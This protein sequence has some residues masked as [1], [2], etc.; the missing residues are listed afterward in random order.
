MVGAIVAGFAWAY[1]AKIFLRREHR[2]VIAA[3]LLSEGRCATCAYPLSDV[4]PAGTLV[5]C[6]ECGSQWKHARLGVLRS[7]GE[8]PKRL[9]WWRSLTQ[10]PTVTDSRDRALRLTSVSHGFLRQRLGPVRG[11]EARAAVLR[12][13]LWRRMI[14]CGLI[15]LW[16]AFSLMPL[17]RTLTVRGTA[18]QTALAGVYAVTIITFAAFCTVGMWRVWTGRGTATSRKIKAALVT[19]QVCPACAAEMRGIEPAPDGLHEC[20]DCGA[21]WGSADET[22]QGPRP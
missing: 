21:A 11:D 10:P 3:T 12:V 8:P 1:V 19:A 17:S 18:S 7:T 22:Q 13:L 20:P 5:K 9:T 15:L 2:G 16:I 4:R 6:P 14:Q